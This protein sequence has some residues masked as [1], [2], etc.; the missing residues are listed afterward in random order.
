MF[1]AEPALTPNERFGVLIMC[2]AT[3]CA[4]LLVTSW[5][6]AHIKKDQQAWNQTHR[7]IK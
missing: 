4:V 5:I 1:T 7:R 3:I 2:L 6:D